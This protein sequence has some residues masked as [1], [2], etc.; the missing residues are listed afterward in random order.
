M[1][2]SRICLRPFERSL[3]LTDPYF[4]PI[5]EEAVDLQLAVAVHVANGSP[6]LAEVL[7]TGRPDSGWAKFRIPVVVAA[8]DIITSQIHQ[9]FPSLNWGMIE[10]SA[11]WMT[12]IACEIKSRTGKSFGPESNPFIDSNLFVTCQGSDDIPYLIRTLGDDVLVIGTDYGHTDPASDIDA[13]LQFTANPEIE[14]DSKRKILSINPSRLY[15]LS[16]ISAV[17]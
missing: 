13:I 7:N 4:Y 14:P 9:D 12:W 3:H 2:R 11:Q 8:F 16:T 10:A 5:Y 17:S 15:S 6:L 1:E